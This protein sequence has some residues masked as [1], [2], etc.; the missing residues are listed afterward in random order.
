MHRNRRVSF[1]ILPGWAR[2]TWLVPLALVLSLFPPLPVAPALGQVDP[3]PEPNNGFNNAC[4]VGR[5][6]PTVLGS[7]SSGNDVDAYKFQVSDPVA[8]V[9]VNKFFGVDIRAEVP[10]EWLERVGKQEAKRAKTLL[11]L[12]VIRVA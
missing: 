11:D 3:C 7:L 12:P 2:Q 5:S 8:Q 10:V 4:F 9:R 6:V 1:R